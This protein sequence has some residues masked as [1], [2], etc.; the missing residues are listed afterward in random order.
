MSEDDFDE[1]YEESTS[2]VG[3][4]TCEHEADKHSW[5]SCDIGDCPCEAGWEE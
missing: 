3:T 5:G 1:D 4:C 2:F